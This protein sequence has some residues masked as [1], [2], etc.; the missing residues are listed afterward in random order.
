MAVLSLNY[1]FFDKEELSAVTTSATNSDVIKIGNR[2][3]VDGKELV[4]DH[5]QNDLLLGGLQLIVTGSADIAGTGTLS[6][7]VYT[8]SGDGNTATKKIDTIGPK[9]PD[10][11]KGT[12]YFKLQ[13][14]SIEQNIKLGLVA[15]AASA[16]SAGDVTIALTSEM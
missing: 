15:S 8:G 3:K 14:A 13:G 11:L 5:V 7:E 12:H 10:E 9:G 1:S 16:F 6:I 2:K 4:G